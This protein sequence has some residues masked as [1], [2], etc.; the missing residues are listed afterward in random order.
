MAKKFEHAALDRSARRDRCVFVFAIPDASTCHHGILS[1][2]CF[3][4]AVNAYAAA[5]HDARV[6]CFRVDFLSLLRTPVS[7]AE[8]GSR[9][10]NQHRQD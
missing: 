2:P 7:G 10:T 8:H 3:S 5:H 1:L 4:S 9:F 6:R